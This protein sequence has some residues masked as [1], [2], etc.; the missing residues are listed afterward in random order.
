VK[1]TTPTRVDRPTASR[2]ELFDKKRSKRPGMPST[3]S[4][5]ITAA[6]EPTAKISASTANW[7]AGDTEPSGSAQK[8]PSAP[9]V[10][11]CTVA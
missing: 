7:K 5:A 6:V 1:R 2:V 9:R 4:G 8:N 10:V 11:P 3:T